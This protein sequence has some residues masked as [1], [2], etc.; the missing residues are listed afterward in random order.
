MGSKIAKNDLFQNNLKN[1]DFSLAK[2]IQ[3]NV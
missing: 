1:L 2:M 3:K